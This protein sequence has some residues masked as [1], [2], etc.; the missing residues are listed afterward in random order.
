MFQTFLYCFVDIF[1]LTL[2]A[3]QLHIEHMYVTFHSSQVSNSREGNAL[4]VKLITQSLMVHQ[5]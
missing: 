3:D 2:N 5:Y 1:K 4:F